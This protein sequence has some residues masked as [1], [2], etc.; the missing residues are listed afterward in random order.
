MLLDE[1]VSNKSSDSQGSIEGVNGECST[2]HYDW[3]CEDYGT[4]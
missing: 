2:A 3:T 4:K 1:S